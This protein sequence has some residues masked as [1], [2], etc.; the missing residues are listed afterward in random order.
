MYITQSNSL[1]QQGSYE[2]A[3]RWNG[4]RW[5]RVQ[6]GQTGTWEAA[7]SLSFISIVSC[8]GNYV[9]SVPVHFISLFVSNNL[10][11]ITRGRGARGKGGGGG[12][13]FAVFTDGASA[14]SR[15]S[16]CFIFSFLVRFSASTS[17]SFPGLSP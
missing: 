12:K 11:A 14:V 2:L 9:P 15:G 16:G 8:S 10:S 4:Q 17:A 6:G 1:L 3:E 13:G 7:G 5:C